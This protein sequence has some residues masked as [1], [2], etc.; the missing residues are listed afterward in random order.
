MGICTS[1]AIKKPLVD[2]VDDMQVTDI[3]LQDLPLDVKHHLENYAAHLDAHV[4]SQFIMNILSAILE[5]VPEGNSK[6]T[7]PKA[8]V[9]CSSL[10]WRRK[11]TAFCQHTNLSDTLC[12]SGWPTHSAGV[13]AEDISSCFAA[14]QP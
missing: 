1:S 12:F 8:K 9:S 5:T 6:Q 3:P 2:C 10:Q 11:Q 14:A 7:A 4:V 13:A